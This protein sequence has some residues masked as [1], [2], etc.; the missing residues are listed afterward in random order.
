MPA[1]AALTKVPYKADDSQERCGTCA[2]HSRL[3]GLCL[4]AL[5]G[6][7][8]LPCGATT[9]PVPA[10]QPGPGPTDP[11]PKPS[12]PRPTPPL[13]NPPPPAPSPAPAPN[14]IPPP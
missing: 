14:P 2:G 9:D 10:P 13:P 4:L 6:L 1:A 7:L 12:D 11:V 3:T 5:I 8:S